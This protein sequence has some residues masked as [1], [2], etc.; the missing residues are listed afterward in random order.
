MSKSKKYDAELAIHK[1]SLIYNE[2][3]KLPANQIKFM[4][5]ND[6]VKVNDNN[7]LVNR[8]LHKFGVDGSLFSSQKNYQEWQEKLINAVIERQNK[9][10]ARIYSVAQQQDKLD[11]L[12]NFFKNLDQKSKDYF[13]E[14][15]T[16]V[17]DDGILIARRQL[18]EGVSGS[19]FASQADYYNWRR[20]IVPS[21]RCPILIPSHVEEIKVEIDKLLLKFDQLNEK[22]DIKFKQ[23]PEKYRDL[24][25]GSNMMLIQLRANYEILFKPSNRIIS[26]DDINLFYTEC[27]S[28]LNIGREEFAMHRG[29]GACNSIIKGILGVLAALTVIP[30][31]IVESKSKE[32]YIATFF[33]QTKTDS[34]DSFDTVEKEFNESK[35][36]PTT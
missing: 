33:K 25:D 6:D 34:A 13:F 17:V 2:L 19:L 24:Y 27:Q 9:R 21:K 31:L 30:A 5:G 28:L 18:R 7:I 8:R 23:A 12:T 11:E 35:N 36:K 14:S 20:T 1:L 26:Q 3:L 29:F 32:G 22:V 16:D 15:S 10:D 4:T